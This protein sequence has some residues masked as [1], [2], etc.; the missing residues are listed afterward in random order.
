[1]RIPEECNA[2][3]QGNY[4]VYLNNPYECVLANDFEQ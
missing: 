3:S 4:I 2:E 1:M